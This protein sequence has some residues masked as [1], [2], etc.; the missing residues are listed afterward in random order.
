MGN[1]GCYGEGMVHFVLKKLFAEVINRHNQF[2]SDFLELPYVCPSSDYAANCMI[3]SLQGDIW[4]TPNFRNGNEGTTTF[5]LLKNLHEARSEHWLGGRKT[6]ADI[7]GLD[8]YGNPLWVIEIKRTS[9]SDKAIK[10]AKAKGIPLFVIDVTRLP[11]SDDSVGRPLA[12]TSSNPFWAMIENAQGGHLSRAVETYNTICE[13]E[14]FGMGPTDTHWGRLDA[15]ICRTHGDCDSD[16]CKDYEKILLHQCGG[17]EKD[18]MLCPDTAYMW[19]QGITWY[20][21]YTDPAHMAHSHAN[22]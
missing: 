12:M 21:M 2:S 6:R 14:A 5:D 17:R 22:N 9:V 19:N 13:R 4:L 16:D 3:K 20:E 11:E 18:T 10:Y 1:A 8:Q 7:A 15:L